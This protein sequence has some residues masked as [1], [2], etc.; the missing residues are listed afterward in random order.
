MKVPESL[1][2]FL[3]VEEAQRVRPAGSGDRALPRLQLFPQMDVVERAVFRVTRDADFEVSD[4]ADDL[5]EAVELRAAPRFGDV[6]R[7]EVSRRSPAGCSC[8]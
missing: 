2:R 5:L 8:S 1:P 6:V 3:E 7:L 4:E